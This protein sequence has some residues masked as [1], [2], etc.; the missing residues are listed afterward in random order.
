MESINKA[1]SIGIPE[2]LKAAIVYAGGQVVFDEELLS[3]AR[4]CKIIISESLSKEVVLTVVSKEYEHG[5]EY[6]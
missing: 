1:N 5:T 6:L 2:L 3:E 4:D